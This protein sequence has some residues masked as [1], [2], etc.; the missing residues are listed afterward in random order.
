MAP[1]S[2]RQRRG[3]RQRQVSMRDRSTVRALAP[4]PLDV[5]MDP[6]PVARAIGELV[7]PSLI[8]GDP[9]GHPDFPPTNSPSVVML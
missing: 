1:A 9:F 5:D 6:L 4:S 8:D 3:E 2:M 7:D